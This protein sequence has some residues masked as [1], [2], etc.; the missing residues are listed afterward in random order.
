M[1]N[2]KKR[3]QIGLISVG[4]ILFLVII[5]LSFFVLSESFRYITLG[6]GLVVG[7]FVVLLS[8]NKIKNTRTKTILFLG[9]IGVGLFLILGNNMLRQSVLS[10]SN[11]Q[12]KDGKYYWIAT[13]VTGNTEEGF[14]FLMQPQDYDIPNTDNTLE[15][16]RGLGLLIKKESS[17]CTYQVIPKTYTNSGIFGIFGTS[18]ID[19]YTLS[20][21]ERTANIKVTNSDDKKFVIL[22]GTAGEE[23]TIKDKDG[24]GE[25]RIQTQGALQI[26]QDCPSPNGIAIAYNPDNGDY[27]FMIEE[28]YIDLLQ[29]S[30]DPFIAIKGYNSRN[31]KAI[32]FINSFETPPKFDGSEVK[33]NTEIGNVLYTISADADYFNAV[34][35]TPPTEANPII[36]DIDFPNSICTGNTGTIEVTVNYGG[37]KGEVI[38]SVDAQDSSVKPSSI[39]RELDKTLTE[40]FRLQSGVNPVKAEIIVEVC[41]KSQFSNVNCDSETIKIT[42]NECTEEEEAQTT[43]CGDNICNG[44][45]TETSCVEDCYSGDSVTLISETKQNESLCEWY[46]QEVTVTELD[47]GA[48]Y[49]KKWLDFIPTIDPE[50]RQVKEC[51]LASWVSPVLIVIVILI[52][53][54]IALLLRKPKRRRRR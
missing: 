21:F 30:T 4:V 16:Q 6:G 26:K 29:Q 32:G 46:E 28:I 19:Y 43:Y 42:Q 48:F 45:E 25:V 34:V 40:T 39:T 17:Y 11:V 49:Y 27:I 52:L 50:E 31:P 7:S 37:E 51:R 47:Y 24:N 20:S 44:A 2:Q 18:T 13:G 14:T 22:D 41:A 53:G 36:K 5:F 12:L 54:T 10:V 38:L 9:L 8:G 3:G 35:Y 23:A 15:P 33:G 1:I